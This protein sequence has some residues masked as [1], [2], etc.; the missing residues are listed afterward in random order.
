MINLF[1]PSAGDA[2]LSAIEHVF[3]SNWLGTGA[4]VEQFERAFAEFLGRPPSE[5]LAISSCTEGLFQAVAALGLGPGDDV[6]LPAISFIGAA[7]A[8]RSV[9]ARVVVCDVDSASLNPTV[10]HIER[11]VTPDTKAVAI[12]HYGGQP[13]AVDEIAK[14]AR[15][16]SLLLIE[17]AACSLG[18]F[19]EGRACGT[20]GDVGVWSFDSMKIVTTGDGGMVWC[21]NERTAQRIRSSVRLGVAS[22]GFGRRVGSS[23]WWEIDPSRAGRRGTLNDI[24]AAMGVIQLSRLPSFLRRREL[25]AATYDA[26][27]TDVPWLSAP[28]RSSSPAARIFYWIQV[29]PELRDRLATHLLGRD[30][31]S[32]FRYWPLHRTRMY[33]CGGSFPGADRAAASTL[34]LPLHQGLSDRDVDHVLDAMHAFMP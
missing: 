19:R 4:R 3:A 20:F 24:A 23:R 28:L 34:L 13:G 21:R 6:I 26:E 10:E 22:S 11:T 15:A 7:H 31:Y 33:S 27:L 29:A 2:E 12:L 16:R 1:Q 18:S 9:G 32:S 30:V 14:F 8:I 25:I 5:V 17:D